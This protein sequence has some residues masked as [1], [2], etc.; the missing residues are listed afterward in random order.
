MP[1]LEGVIAPGSFFDPAIIDLGVP[2]TTTVNA[3]KRSSSEAF[4]RR[5]HLL[6]NIFI[7][8]RLLTFWSSSH[9]LAVKLMDY[10]APK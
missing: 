8:E 4:G 9:H 5:S 3:P 6:F 7:G 10:Y 1:S 2:A